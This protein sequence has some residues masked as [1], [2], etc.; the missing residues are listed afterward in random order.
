MDMEAVG[1][2]VIV[3]PKS[4]DGLRRLTEHGAEVWSAR[5]LQPHLGYTEW[6]NFAKAIK[7]AIKSCAG[8][9][10]EPSHHFV[11]VTKMIDLGKGGKRK[12]LDYELS[13]FACYLILQSGDTSKVEIAVAQKYFAIQTRRQE[14]SDQLAADVERVALRDQTRKGHKELSGV[15]KQA[16]V[17]SRH[18]G[19]FHDAGYKGLYNGIGCNEI[20]RRKGI[21]T[22][23]VLMDRMGTTELAANNFRLTQARDKIASSGVRTEA[24]ATKINQAVG[25][26]VREAIKKI[27]GEL[28]ENLPAAEHIKQVAKRLRKAT[29]KLELRPSDAI[30]LAVPPEVPNTNAIDYGDL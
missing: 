26:E 13:R 17:H 5:D 28:P 2:T 21:P 10:N 12:T 29:P 14:L 22:A 3:A 27:G 23:D 11:E 1:S 25:E 8:S 6:R 19:I 16:G 4:L 24:Q 7:R 9:G 20:K 18:F 30:G 15:A